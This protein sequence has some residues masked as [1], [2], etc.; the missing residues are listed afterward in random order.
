MADLKSWEKYEQLRLRGE[1]MWQQGLSAVEISRALGVA[2]S[3]V[4]N[5]QSRGRGKEAVIKPS[6]RKP[7]LS[8]SQRQQLESL[9]E[10]G[11]VA[12]GFKTEIWT[13]KRIAQVIRK[14][15]GVRYHHKSIPRVL[16]EMGWSCQKPRKAALERDEEKIAHWKRHKWPGIKKKPET[17]RR[18]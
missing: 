10:K 12:Y 11:A 1:A 16:H 4:Y 17:G 9:L 6:G 14:K 3:T 8:L 2:R 7:A 15:F 5:W 13:G 18:S